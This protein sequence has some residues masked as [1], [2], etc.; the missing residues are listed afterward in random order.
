MTLAT[1]VARVAPSFAFPPDQS[2]HQT[3]LNDA[4]RTHAVPWTTRPI[5]VA[6]V[7]HVM[8][9]AGAEVLVRETIRQLGARIEPTIFCLDSVGRIG[10]ELQAQGVS[11]VCFDRKPKLDLSVS[12]KMASV[13]RERRIQVVH[14][15]QYTP[16]FYAA[17][18]KIPALNAFKLVLTEHGRHYPDTVSPKRRAV[19]RMVLDHLADAV[20]GCCSFSAVALS[21]VDGFRGRRIEVIDNGIDLQQYQ[22]N[23]DRQAVRRRL[24]LDPARQYVSCI[25]RFHPVK[26]HPMLLRAFANV[27]QACPTADLL[28]AGEGE[29]RAKLE[30]LAAELGITQRVKFLGVR[31]DVPDVLA[32]SD[33][34]ALMSVSEAASLTLLEAMATSCPPVV[35]DVG[36]N[37]ELVRHGVDGLLV[38]RGDAQAAAVALVQILSDATYAER[39]GRSARHR[40]EE[41]FLLA[42]TI[43][44]HFDVYRRL[45]GRG[46]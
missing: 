11:V 43:E 21:R 27:A 40:V 19:N 9:V 15:H 8:Q 13:I 10:E 25:A 37:P 45:T 28:L 29:G 39:L 4:P 26:D 6:F 12:W 18:A 36:G 46:A 17:L 7:V 32:A 33:V 3:P 5:R 20:N 38:P 2:Q 31:K 42:D 14:A 44:K 1:P 23:P 41:K 30:A 22:A 16:F 24:G 34:F 35:T